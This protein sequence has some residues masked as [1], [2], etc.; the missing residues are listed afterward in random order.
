MCDD[1]VATI[2]Q[3]NEAHKK[4]KIKSQEI[5]ILIP[6]QLHG[7]YES[8]FISLHLSFFIYEIIRLGSEL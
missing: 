8:S 1:Q 3:N 2:G 7:A 4:E 5:C 6:A